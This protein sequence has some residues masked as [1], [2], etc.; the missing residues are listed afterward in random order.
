MFTQA[1]KQKKTKTIFHNSGIRD[2]SQIINYKQIKKALFLHTIDIW[3]TMSYFFQSLNSGA[4]DAPHREVHC[5]KQVARLKEA[6]SV[7]LTPCE[8]RG[9]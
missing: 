6:H 8:V 7:E 5:G 3:A 4:P 9:H 1:K 2:K